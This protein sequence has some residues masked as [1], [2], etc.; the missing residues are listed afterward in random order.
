M[1][2]EG[3]KDKKSMKQNDFIK[4]MESKGFK[5]TKKTWIKTFCKKSSLIKCG[6]FVGDKSQIRHG[7]LIE[8]GI[9]KERTIIIDGKEIAVSE[10]S[11]ASLKEQLMKI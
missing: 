2:E 3:V 4:F 9:K 6:K 5:L 1:G 11:F 8:T 7:N 10:D